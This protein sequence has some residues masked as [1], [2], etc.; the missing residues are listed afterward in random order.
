MITR[1]VRPRCGGICSG[2]RCFIQRDKD[3]PRQGVVANTLNSFRNGAVGF[4]YWL[5]A[6]VCI[7]G[8]DAANFIVSRDQVFRIK[9]P[10][11]SWIIRISRNP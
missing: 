4:I 11:F 6:L 8:D 1:N 3:K 7:E 5:D 10:V 9:H 2:E